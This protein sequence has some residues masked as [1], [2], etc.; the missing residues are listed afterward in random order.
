MLTLFLGKTVAAL[1]LGG[2]FFQPPTPYAFRD[3]FDPEC[4]GLSM[5]VDVEGRGVDSYRNVAG[6]DGQAFMLT[7]TYRNEEVWTNLDTGVSFTITANA[8][9]RESNPVPVALEDVPP[10][11]IPAEGLVGPVYRFTVRLSGQPFT[12][13][14]SAGEVV[15]REY[16]VLEWDLLFD[17][18]GDREP[19][20][21]ALSMDLVRDIGSHPTQEHGFDLCTL[22][23]ELTA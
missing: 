17:T 15:I 7:D 4:P 21:R 18:L 2:T 13:R 12:L 6:S 19:G 5:R 9:V 3:S 20:G 11:L 14:D 16:G 8:S 10:E 23:A 1:A 22:A